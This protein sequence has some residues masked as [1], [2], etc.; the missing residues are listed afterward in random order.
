MMCQLMVCLQYLC[1]ISFNAAVCWIADLCAPPPPP[2]LPH[3]R[4]YEYAQTCTEYGYAWLAAIVAVFEAGEASPP[5]SAARS[6]PC[7][8]L[9]R[10]APTL[11]A[12]L[13][14]QASSRLAPSTHKAPASQ[15]FLPRAIF[16]QLCE[17]LRYLHDKGLVAR[18]IST[19]GAAFF[20]NAGRWRF[21]DFTSWARRG[22][23]ASLNTPLRYAA[24]EV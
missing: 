21:T 22:D 13:G 9:E 19:E 5:G 11:Q 2:P 1:S 3:M 7:L 12:Y 23:E 10:G 4:T 14:Q 8:V 17:S 18:Q 6:P 16:I 24:P 15:S 20:E